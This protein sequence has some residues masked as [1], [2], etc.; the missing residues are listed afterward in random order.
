MGICRDDATT[1]LRGL[2]YNAVRHP[3]TALL[4]L[5][6]IG[7]QGKVCERLGQLRDLVDSPAAQPG[8][9]GPSPA[10]ELS[11]SKSSRL[12]LHIGAEILGAFV[13]AMGGTLG[14]ST[15]YT[16]AKRLSFEFAQVTKKSVSPAQAGSFLTSGDLSKSNPTLVPWV[17]GRGQIYL[18]TEVA[19]STHFAVRYEQSAG[20][21]ASVDLPALGELAGANVGV[22]A[23]KSESHV[24]SFKGKEP[25]AFAFK[26]FQMGYIDG[27]LA[28]TMIKPGAVAL[29]DALDEQ[30]QPIDPGVSLTALDDVQLIEFR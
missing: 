19:Y 7:K 30:G 22:E 20:Q 17:L 6:V 21:A 16:N 29:S 23:E 27:R 9:Q 2:G 18:V 10:A 12:S 13:G 25:L 3:Y 4:P 15:K 11:G 8:L 14:A 5:E 26:C 28:L 1:Y 24:V